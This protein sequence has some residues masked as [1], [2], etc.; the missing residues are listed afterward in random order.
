M[1]E[2]HTEDASRLRSYYRHFARVE[3]AEVSPLYA[4]WAAGLAADNDVVEPD[5]RSWQDHHAELR[6]LTVDPKRH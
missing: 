2:I 1:R 3:A 4:E 6:R 5:Q